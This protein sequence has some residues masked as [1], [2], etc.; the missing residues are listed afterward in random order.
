MV[1]WSRAATVTAIVYCSLF[2]NFFLVASFDNLGPRLAEAHNISLETLALI[3]SIK[4]FV[5]MI[6]GPLFAL[7]SSR[8]PAYLLFSIGGLSVSASMTAMAFSVS[9]TGFFIARTLHGIGTS[10]LMVGGMSVLMRCVRKKER[11][12]YSSIAYS[13]AGHA[14]LVA[15]VLSGLMYGNLSQ[16]WTFL[17]IA[18]LTL[19]V[20]GVSYVVLARV[21]KVPRIEQSESQLT[22][23]ERKMIIPCVKGMFSS[24]ITYIAVAGILSHGFS[25]GSCE[26]TL[27][28]ALTEWNNS[29]LPVLT[30]SLIYSVG[31][32]MFTLVAPIA[33]Y[34]VDMTA[35]YKVLIFGLVMYV[36]I[37]PF[38]DMLSQTLVGLGACIGI[39]FAIGAICEVS[40]Y[41]FVAEIGELTG[42]AHADTV[43]YAMNELFIQAGYATGNVGGRAIYDWRGFLAMGCFISALNC[44][45]IGVSATALWLRNRRGKGKQSPR[46][47]A[48]YLPESIVQSS[49]S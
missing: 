43:A 49:T 38:L 4:S 9:E 28:A 13:S 35:H 7:I 16:M 10:G 12:R 21:T 29:S 18:C 17:I 40:V 41:P 47:V 26:T 37:F 48:E 2:L 20:T 24:P 34:F 8:V 14:P 32:L 6:C 42:I 39:A 5:N 25:F 44:V 3:A 31:P 36:V 23:I 22:T 46:P 11:G 27:A 1:K 33:G 15:P 45:S 19:A 30:T